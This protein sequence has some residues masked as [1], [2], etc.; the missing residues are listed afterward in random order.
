[1]EKVWLENDFI[2]SCHSLPYDGQRGIRDREFYVREHDGQIGG[3]YVDKN[4]FGARFGISTT[5]ETMAQKTAV[6][7]Y[8]NEIYG[9]KK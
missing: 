8:L 1:V 3:E 6:V 2:R 9:T 7:L 5:A 4:N